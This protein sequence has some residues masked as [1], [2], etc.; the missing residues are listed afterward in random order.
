MLLIQ[1]LGK[2]LETHIYAKFMCMKACFF[3]KVTWLVE[4]GRELP[5]NRPGNFRVMDSGKGSLLCS[6]AFCPGM[7]RPGKSQRQELH[8]NSEVTT[9]QDTEGENHHC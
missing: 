1:T 3:F 6:L 5:G 9:P 2:H 4:I 8:C 7:G